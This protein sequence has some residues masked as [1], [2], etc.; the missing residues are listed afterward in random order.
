V[1]SD[2]TE[3]KTVFRIVLRG[4]VVAARYARRA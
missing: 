2:T 3:I 4:R 1:S